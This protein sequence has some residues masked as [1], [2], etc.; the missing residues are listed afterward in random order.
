MS[1]DARSS[2]PTP[3]PIP[4]A[5]G[6]RLD[7]AG[8]IGAAARVPGRLETSEA[9][10]AGAAPAAGE[11][12]RKRGIAWCASTANACVAVFLTD[13]RRHVGLR[14]FVLVH[15]VFVIVQCFTRPTSRQRAVPLTHVF[16]PLRVVHVEAFL[17]HVLTRL[18][19]VHVSG[20]GL[21]LAGGVMTGV[22]PACA[23][24]TA[25]DAPVAAGAAAGHASTSSA[26]TSAVSDA[27]PMMAL[28]AGMGG[29]SVTAQPA[30]GA[31]WADNTLAMHG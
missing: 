23:A 20:L 27:R 3:A 12:A 28:V 1:S 9:A 10:V 16:V 14:S 6:C 17:T 24:C 2:T 18:L 21:G 5:A 26:R 25:G 22:P 13:V 29:I 11:R 4:L 8:S 7:A 15:V 31:R 30:L 19:T